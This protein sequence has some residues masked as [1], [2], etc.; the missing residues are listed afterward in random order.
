MRTTNTAKIIRGALLTFFLVFAIFPLYWIVLTS[1]KDTKEIFT[2]PLIYFPSELSFESYGKLFQITDFALYI[3]NSFFV[4]I[5]G[6]VGSLAFAVFSGYAL[7]R[8]GF[9]KLKNKLLLVLY[10]TQMVPTFLF[11]TPLYLMVAGVRGTDNL[12]ML[13]VVYM[14]TNLSF[15]T[16]MSK[17]FFDRL[18]ASIEES[19]LVDGCSAI[20]ALFQI[21]IP[22]MKP[23]LAAIFSFSFVGIWN[24]LF[25]AVLFLNNPN[26]TTVAVAL[27]SFI[28]KAGVNWD[29]L[30]AGIVIAL[31]P[32]MIIFAIAQKHI[33]AGLT[34]GG[35]KGQSFIR[36]LRRTYG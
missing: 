13:A 20:Q 30:S 15:G 29:V 5:L 16:I 10:I 4:T 22:L 25:M 1:L 19:A 31:L 21:T 14:A 17:S 3:G 6:S 8:C 2:F 24:E 34:D 27:N 33:V 18:P 26:K 28:S 35:V 23:A 36:L 9:S 11:M 12:S 7:S 32:T